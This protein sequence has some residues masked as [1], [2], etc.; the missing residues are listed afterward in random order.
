MGK[1]FFNKSAIA[2][3]FN[4]EEK[5]LGGFVIAEYRRENKFLRHLGIHL[6]I[7]GENKAFIDLNDGKFAETY[8]DGEKSCKI[9]SAIA[10]TN[11][12]HTMA[13]NCANEERVVWANT[14]FAL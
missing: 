10:G 1:N 5:L 2:K 7:R 9:F 11:G 13:E 12:H 6:N 3:H 4:V 8:K 14:E